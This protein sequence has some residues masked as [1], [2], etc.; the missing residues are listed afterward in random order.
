M[1]RAE[2]KVIAGQKERKGKKTKKKDGQQQTTK[3]RHT[4]D[5][6]DANDLLRV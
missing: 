2:C 6:R 3:K 5:A 1:F 4:V